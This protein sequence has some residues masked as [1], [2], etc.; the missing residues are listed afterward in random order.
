MDADRR[1]GWS[2]IV[3]G[4]AHTVDNPE[5]I[6]KLARLRLWPWADAVARGHWVRI[7]AYEVTGRK[8][9]HS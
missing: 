9:V 4:H 7:T 5:D 3:R 8:I 1:A 2:V 6:E